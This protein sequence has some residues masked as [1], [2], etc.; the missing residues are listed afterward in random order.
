MAKKQGL[1]EFF[2]LWVLIA[3]TKDA[4]LKA[5]QREYDRFHIT[6][7][8]RAVLWSIKYYGG[9]ASPTQ[10]AGYLFRELNSV[11]EM[12]KRM[13]AEGLIKKYKGTSGTSVLVKITK[14]GVGIFDQSH[15]N[16][17]DGKILSILSKKQREQ[18]ATYLW[19]VRSQALKELGI[20]GWT[21][22]FPPGP[23][24]N[25]CVQEKIKRKPK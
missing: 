3:Q 18:L 12:L 25:D 20:P 6:N 21:R 19:A 16:E 2:N 24:N 23:S 11:S 1:D 8:R 5:R 10:I 15:H 22:P 13:E 17:T 7:E 4:F 9:Q 14:K